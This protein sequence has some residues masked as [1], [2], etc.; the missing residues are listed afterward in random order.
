MRL[1]IESAQGPTCINYWPDLHFLP[2]IIHPMLI[3]IFIIIKDQLTSDRN[4]DKDKD[5]DKEE[6][7][8]LAGSSVSLPTSQSIEEETDC[9]FEELPQ[10]NC[11][12]I[13]FINFDGDESPFNLSI[14]KYL[15]KYLQYISFPYEEGWNVLNQESYCHDFREY[16]ELLVKNYVY[17]ELTE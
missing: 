4:A 12:K 13:T 6:K 17:S 1:V 14:A 15:C 3:C 8:P 2:D 5:K 7:L 9:V 10:R 11:S 16:S